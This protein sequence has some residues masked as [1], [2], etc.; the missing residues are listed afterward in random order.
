MRKLLYIVL[1]CT[2]FSCSNNGIEVEEKNDFYEFNDSSLL[3]KNDFVIDTSFVVKESKDAM[4][5]FVNSVEEFY[6][7]GDSY[8]NFK[9]ALDPSE[10]LSDITNEG[11]ELLFQAYQYIVSNTDEEDMSGETLIL[12][13][14]QILLR[15]KDNNIDKWEDIDFE[16]GSIW[17]FGLDENSPFLRNALMAKGGCKW[18]QLGCHLASIWNWFT[19]TASGGGMTNGTAIVAAIAVFTGIAGIIALF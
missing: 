16:E 11:N 7:V 10:G 2:M 4:I 14:N 3:K 9:A 12:A 13:F 6:K 15:A 8:E 19:S 1:A 5:S 18:Y 17:L